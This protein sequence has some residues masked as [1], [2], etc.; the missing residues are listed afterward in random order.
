MEEKG[1]PVEK[2]GGKEAQAPTSNSG[3]LNDTHQP[4]EK[5]KEAGE[6]KTEL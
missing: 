4:L 3:H 2:E 5:L 1:E 6:V